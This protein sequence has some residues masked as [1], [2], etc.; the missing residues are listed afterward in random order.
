MT[1]AGVSVGLPEALAERMAIQTVMGAGA[2][3]ARSVDSP[4]RLREQVTSPGGT[5][6]AALGVLMKQDALRE[7]L[8]KAITAARDRGRELART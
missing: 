5:T 1:A 3:A 8:A 6:A 2:Y 7:L 4:Q